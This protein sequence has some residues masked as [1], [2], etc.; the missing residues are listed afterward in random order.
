MDFFDGGVGVQAT[1]DA[2]KGFP[3]TKRYVSIALLGTLVHLTM[4]CRTNDINN[5]VSDATNIYNIILIHDP[6]KEFLPRSKDLVGF[7]KQVSTITLLL[8]S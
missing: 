6:K 3:G 5:I 7:T 4:L 8:V 1:I 2:R